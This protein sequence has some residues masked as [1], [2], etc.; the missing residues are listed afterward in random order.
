MRK[1]LLVLGALALLCAGLAADTPLTFSHSDAP[2][3]ND[4]RYTRPELMAKWP[5]ISLA[6]AQRLLGQ[7]GV[8]FVDGRAYNEWQAGHLPGAIALPV[9]EFDKRWP[10]HKKELRKAK[11]VVIYCHGENCGMADTVADL[12]SNKGLRNM[13]VF[14]G[15]F[16]AWR[17]A[18]LPYRIEPGADGGPP[19]PPAKHKGKTKALPLEKP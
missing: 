13:A 6:E 7:P 11:V 9:G 4:P 5:H 14:W 15:G 3:T 2:V 8:L 10:M 12:L 17:D 18:S 19:L 16:P 1:T